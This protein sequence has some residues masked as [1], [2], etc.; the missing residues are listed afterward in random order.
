MA[1]VKKNRARPG[2]APTLTSAYS[3]VA[4]DLMQRIGDAQAALMG[5]PT[6]TEDQ[7][8]PAGNDERVAAWNARNPEATDDA[9]LRMAFQK[10]QEHLAAG[11]PSEK[12]ERATAE[13]LTHYR[14]G[15]KMKVYTYGT[16]GFTEQ[17]ALAQRMAKL[18]ARESTPEPL[19]PPPAMPSAAMTN[20]EMAP[21]APA[22]D[23]SSLLENLGAPTA[24]PLAPSPATVPQAPP[25]AAQP[26]EIPPGGVL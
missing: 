20:A 13:D 11:M 23:G 19:P 21:A 6:S 7:V 25:P 17:V 5:P 1:T 24:P 12:A 8:T 22:L 18:A 4:S 14:Y 15:Q 2:G 3:A 9:M 10:Y 26:P 16:V